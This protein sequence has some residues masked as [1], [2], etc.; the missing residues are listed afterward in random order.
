MGSDGGAEAAHQLHSAVKEEVKA[1]YPDA[2]SDWSIVVQVVLNLHGL[3]T[4]LQMLGMISNANEL[5]AF[6]RA[7]GQLASLLCRC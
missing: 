7:F 1:T 2:I 4:K 5:A 3:A 6:G